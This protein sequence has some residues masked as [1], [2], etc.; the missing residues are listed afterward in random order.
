MNDDVCAARGPGG[1]VLAGRTI[2]GVFAHPDDESFACGGTLARAADAGARVVLFCASRGEAGSTSD[3]ALVPDGDLGLERTAELHRAAAVLGVADVVVM[4]HADGQLRWRDQ[5]TLA[6]DIVAAFQRYQPDAVITFAEDGLYWH[7]DH[8]AVHERTNASIRSLGDNAPPLYYV[9]LPPRRMREIL[10][11][12]QT[13]RSAPPDLSF[14]GIVPDAFGL[15]AQPPTFVV[16]VSD[17]TA[18]K[19]EALRCHRTQVGADNP[20]QWIDAEQARRFLGMEY[21]RRSPI[22]SRRDAVLELLADGNLRV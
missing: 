8:I 3:P 15:A 9:T 11:A 16:D 1:G 2:L 22:E 10:E 7:P 6:A 19:L 17:W 20:F 21:F 18:R 13:S 14:W 4:H 12:I 5:L